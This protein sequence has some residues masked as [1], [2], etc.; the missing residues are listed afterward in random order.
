MDACSPWVNNCVGIGNHKAF[1]LLLAYATATS[2]HAALFIG[3]QLALCSG[4]ACGLGEGERPGALG[5]W[6]LAG[7]CVFGLFCS[8]MLGMELYSIQLEPLFSRIADEISCRRSSKSRSR[9]ERHLSVVCGTNG[10]SLLWLV[11]VAPRRSRRETEI[12]LGFRAG[13]SGDG[14]C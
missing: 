10:F 2:A 6:V 12:V 14:V 8:L 5:V 4:N 1:L 13:G 3:A 11:P 9:L 7:A